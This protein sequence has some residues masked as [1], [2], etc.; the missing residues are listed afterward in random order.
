MSEETTDHTHAEEAPVVK[1][2]TGFAV[3]I[4]AD[5][6]IFIEK[7]P[8]ILSIEV[9]REATLVEV[10]RACSEIVMDLQAQTAAEYTL[11]RIAALDSAKEAVTEEK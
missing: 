8:Q 3:F 9:D 1:P 11:L 2:A 4:S 10:R 7:N 5:G 6:H